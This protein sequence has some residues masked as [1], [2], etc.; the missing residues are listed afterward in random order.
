[1]QEIVFFISHHAVLVGLFCIVIVLLLL[2][3]LIRI[4]RG[5]FYIDPQK[6]VQKINH[7][8]AVVID[9]RPTDMYRK[10]HIIGAL[11]ISAA[12]LRNNPEKL[13]KYKERPIIL[14]CETGEDSRKIAAIF[15]QKYYDA[16]SLKDGMRSWNKADMPL[17]KE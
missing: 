6:T 16:Y 13:E 1:M 12:E 15:Y 7:E 11:S 9:I 14:V 4:R 2:V 17:I 10:N 8:N 5:S 3:E